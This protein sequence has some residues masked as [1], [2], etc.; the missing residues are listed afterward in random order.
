FAGND[1]YRPAAATLTVNVLTNKVDEYITEAPEEK[2]FDLD[3]LFSANL[4]EYSPDNNPIFSDANITISVH[5]ETINGKVTGEYAGQKFSK[6]I[7][8]RAKGE[9][10]EL[11]PWGDEYMDPN[12][13]ET[14]TTTLIIEPKVNMTLYVY[15]RRQVEENKERYEEVD[16]V[17]NNVITCKHYYVFEANDAKS[18]KFSDIDNP[19]PDADPTTSGVY[20]NKN[21]YLGKWDG[22]EYAYGISE[23]DLEAGKSYNVYA[24]GTTYQVQGIGYIINTEDPNFVRRTDHVIEYTTNA[25]SQTDAAGYTLSRTGGNKL[26]GGAK[27]GVDGTEYTSV[28][29]KGIID[30]E[31]Q[32]TYTV[33]APDNKV[34]TKAT[35][36]A[37]TND[38]EPA[39]FTK[40]GN[41][42]FADG[43][44]T[45]IKSTDNKKPTVLTFDHIML[46]SFDME[47]HTTLNKNA[48]VVIELEVIDAE[49]TPELPQVLINEK[50]Y[51]HLDEFFAENNA[52]QIKVSAADESHEIYYKHEAKSAATP[53]MFAARA[54]DDEEDIHAGYT[55]AENGVITV[56][57][58]GTL[59][60]YA[61]DP[62]KKVK[63]APT[64]VVF[65]DVPTGI[66][67]IAAEAAEAEVEYYNLQ[68][69]RVANPEN[70]IF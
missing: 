35:V 4:D 69:I 29:F 20:L 13:V 60:V 19:S 17:D 66:D 16:D 14:A 43:A 27:I 41:L 52:V 30:G 10:N 31:Q 47:I 32:I 28:T 9:P 3:R 50:V 67:V 37:Y 11:D 53:N 40:V 1:S 24:T 45:S 39:Y 61:Y 8:V 23:I 44:T 56:T 58:P 54:I 64:S 46:N 18:L 68:G 34:V 26:S 70:G 51:K 21:A 49:H 2:T 59:T 15:G 25:T 48:Y 6:S 12:G 42:T 55:K 36:Y 5:S 62:A 7:Q 65:T 33:D 63:S 57:E 38:T 22:H